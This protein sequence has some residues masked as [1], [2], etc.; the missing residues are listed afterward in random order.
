MQDLLQWACKAA[1]GS[2]AA[3]QAAADVLTDLI[4]LRN[5]KRMHKQ[6]LN[7]FKGF[8]NESLRTIIKLMQQKVSRALLQDPA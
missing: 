4:F 1:G 6:L 3:G 8:G 7:G 5:S 2:A